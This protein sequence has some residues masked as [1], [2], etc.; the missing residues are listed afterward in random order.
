MAS[1]HRLSGVDDRSRLTVGRGCR[2]V[3]LAP[4]V[5]L[6]GDPCLIRPS[7]R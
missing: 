3:P 5:D 2:Q 4:N 7:A 6:A 1:V